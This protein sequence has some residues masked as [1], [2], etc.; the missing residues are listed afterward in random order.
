S[1][2]TIILS[3]VLEHIRKPEALVKEMYRILAPGGQVIMNVPFYY[4]LHE[5]PFDYYR[6]TQF[7]LRAI[8]EDAGFAVVELEAIG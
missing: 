8:T 6:Y 1:F 7:A 2:D 5:Q 3:D 4:G